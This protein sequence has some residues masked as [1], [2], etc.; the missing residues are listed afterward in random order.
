MAGCSH[1]DHIQITKLPESVEGCATCWRA[2]ASGCTCACAW[3]AA[4]SAAATTR[5]TARVQARARHRA[6]D[7][8]L[9]RARRGLVVVLP[10]RARDAD[11]I[12]QGGDTDSAVADAL[13]SARG[14]PC[15]D[16]ARADPRGVWRRPS[17]RRGD[18]PAA[19]RAPAAGTRSRADAGHAGARADGRRRHGGRADRGRRPGPRRGR[20]GGG[21]LAAGAPALARLRR[22]VPQRDGPGACC[23]RCAAAARCCTSTTSSIACRASGQRRRRAGRLGA[24]AAALRPRL[25]RDVVYCP[26]ELDCPTCRRR[27]RTPQRRRADR[28]LRRAHRAAQGPARPR[29]CRRRDPRGRAGRADRARRRRPLRQRAGLR[30]AGARR[31]GRRARDVGRRRRRA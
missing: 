15:D 8:P 19:S 12:R 30:G 7:H 9:D 23:R 29:P 4:R 28:R 5:R 2:A 31:R 10:R 27:G 11:R 1:L 14:A 18:R 17:G 16:Q 26:V 25:E 22:R 13:L 20:A 21:V 6:P 3:S 24:V